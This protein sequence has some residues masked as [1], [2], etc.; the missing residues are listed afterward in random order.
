MES[1]TKEN[2]RARQEGNSLK[3]AL[4]LSVRDAGRPP[5]LMQLHY[6]SFHMEH[7]HI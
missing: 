7:P 6:E 3:K 2:A 4:S 5:R 1:W